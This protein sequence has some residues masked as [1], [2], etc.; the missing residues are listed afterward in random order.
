M[1]WLVVAAALIG[2]AALL[3]YAADKALGWGRHRRWRR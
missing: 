1:Y 3:A 2:S